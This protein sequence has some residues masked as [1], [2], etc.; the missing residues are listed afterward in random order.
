MEL[1]IIGSDHVKVYVCKAF[2][3]L[4]VPEYVLL[5]CVVLK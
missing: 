2:R 1:K 5:V 4:F 3:V